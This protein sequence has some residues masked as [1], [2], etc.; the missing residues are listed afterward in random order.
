MGS[1]RF[2]FKSTIYIVGATIGRPFYQEIIDWY[3]F[4]D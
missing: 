3:R 2:V 1:R 4:L